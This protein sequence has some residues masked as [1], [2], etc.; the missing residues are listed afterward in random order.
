MI[1]EI[2]NF[3][4]M[5]VFADAFITNGEGPQEGQARKPQS[6][7]LRERCQDSRLSQA[8]YCPDQLALPVLGPAVRKVTQS[9]PTDLP[10]LPVDS[11]AP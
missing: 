8:I 1:G 5:F 6:A 11:I 9:S 7:G 10:E 4:S 2:L 3:E